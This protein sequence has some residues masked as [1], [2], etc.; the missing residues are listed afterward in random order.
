MLTESLNSVHI[1]HVSQIF[2]IPCLD[3]LDLVG[4]TETVEEVDERDT[5]L[6]SCA[7]SYRSQVH[8]FLYRRLTQHSCTGLTAGVNVGV[9]TEDRKCV[10]SDST[11]RYIEHTRKLLTCDLV[12]VRDHQQKTL[13]SRV[14]SGQSTGGQRSVNSTGCT[15]LRLHLCNLNFL[16]ENVLSSL[17]SPFICGL[18]HYRRRSDREDSGNITVSIGSMRCSVVTIHGFHFSCHW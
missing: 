6:D 11:S 8:Y 17:G 14:G 2:V 10:A 13:R 12:Q 5:A 16:T 1:Y 3:L 18:S 15:S 7:V 4:C 9:I